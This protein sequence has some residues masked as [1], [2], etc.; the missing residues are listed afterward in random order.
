MWNNFEQ[1]P[2]EDE[3]IS[4][5][6][7]SRGIFRITSEDEILH[8][9]H[10]QASV[11]NKRMVVAVDKSI[12]LLEDEL[13]AK[14]F[15]LSFNA[16]ID[17][18]AISH[19]GNL[20]VCGLSDGEI[21]GIYIKGLP[22]F[23][24]S[25][26]VE[27]VHVVGGK[28][29]AGIQQVGNTFCVTCTNGSVYSLTE[30]DE[31]PL[32]DKLNASLV[33]NDITDLEKH[34][35]IVCLKRLFTIRGLNEI[36]AALLITQNMDYV[37]SKQ[38]EPLVIA[39]T[40]NAV[41]LRSS[42]DDIVRLNIPEMY[43]GVKEIYNLENF[44]VILTNS[45]H[46]LELCP[47]TKLLLDTSEITD[48][49]LLIDNLIVMDC[50]DEHIEFLI[51]TKHTKQE[52]RCIKIVDYP[53]LKCHNE[54]DVSEHSWLV[55]QP[56]CS[57]NLYYLSGGECNSN[58]LPTILEMILVSET[59]PSERFKK[60]IAK[61][62]LEEAEDFGRQFEL[63]LQP[64]YEAKAKK[65]LVEMNSLG[66]NNP[67]LLNDLFANLMELLHK[68]ENKEFFRQNRMFNIPSRKILEKYLKEVLN[69]LD[70]E[71]DEQHI[72]EIVEQLDRLKTL[73]ILDPYEVNMEW[74][75][76]VYHPNLI[77]YIN[78]LFKTDMSMASLIWKRHS[79][80]I[81]PQLN[82]NELRKLLSLIPSDTKPFNILQWLRQFV[83]VVSNTH[84]NIMPFITDWSIEK[85]R[86]LQYAEHWPEIGL[87]FSTKV[88]E[89]FED[90]QFMHS[91]VRRQH[92]RNIS[93][94]RDLVNALQDLFVLKKSYNL[95]FTLDN[96]LQD[97]IDETA[98]CILLRVHLDNL[99]SLVNDFLYPIYQEKG[100]SP[101]AAIRRYICQL[102]ASR[103]SF[104]TWLERSVACI[105]LLH[106]EDDR[107]ES[108]L[109]VLQNSP[110]PWPDTVDPLI[111]LRYSTHPLALKINTEY[112]IQVIKIMKAKY[113]WPT[114]C[115]SDMNLNLFMFRIIKMD[116]PDMLDDIRILTKAA[117]EIA[118]AAN[119]N[120]CYQMVRKGKPDVACDFFKSLKADI[121]PKHATEVAELFAE[122]L[123]QSPTPLTDEG[124]VEQKNLIEFFKFIT[125]KTCPTAQKRLKAIQNRFILRHKYDLQINDVIDLAPYQNRLHLLSM[126]L[127]NVIKRSQETDN[128]CN[129]FVGEI[130][131]L[132]SALD[133]SKMFVVKRLCQRTK[134]LIITCA[135]TY[136]MLDIV[137]CNKEN[138][139]DFVELALELL[140]Q[141]IQLTKSSQNSST[142]AALLNDNDPLAFPLAYELLVRAS[143]VETGQISELAELINYVRI[144]TTGYS[145]GAISQF[146]ENR[147]K[148][149]SQ[150]ICEA[151]DA[152]EITVGEITL[153]FSTNLNNSFDIKQEIKPKKRYS[154]SVF[155]DV[156]PLPTQASQTKVNHSEH[157]HI[158]KFVSRTLL[159]LI[160]QAP[161]TNHLLIKLKEF[162]FGSNLDIK[163]DVDSAKD[164]FF[165]SLEHLIK[166]K[167]HT[168]WYTMAQYV[169]DYQRRHNCKLINCDFVSLQMG[170]VF[171]H[172]L[173]QKDV[174]FLDLFIMLISD[175]HATMLL[176]KLEHDLKTD[177]QKVNFLILSEMY[178]VHS[179]DTINV[180]NIR[181]KRIKHFYYMEFCK[182]DPSIKGKFN[183]DIDSIEQLLKEFHNKQLDVSLLERMSADFNLD[184]QKMLI[185]QVISILQAQEMQF[186]IKIDSFGDEELVMVT[187]VDSIRNL[188]QPYINEIKNTELLTSKLK[189][190]IDEINLYFYELYLCVIEILLYF[191][192]VP[193]EMQVWTSILHFL[194][195]KMVVRRRN[196]PGQLENDMW[197]ESQKEIGV[198]PKIARYRLPFKP[199]VEQPLKDILDS[200]LNVDN[201]ESWFPLIQMHTVLKG[202]TDIAHNCD[203]FCMSA[204][205]NS[206]TEYKS[207]DDGETW[208]LQPTNN[209]FL[210]SILR[211]VK[212]V[213]NPS[214]AFLILYFVSNYAP[215]GADQVEASYECYKYCIE[216]EKEITDSK[217]QEQIIKIKRNFPILKTQHLLY[218]YG[219]TD[220]KTMRLIENPTELIYHLYHHDILLKGGKLDINTVV[221]EI[222]ELHNLNL[223]T[224]QFKLLQKW[225]SFTVETPDGTVLDETL[226]EDQNLAEN[227]N[228]DSGTSA[229]NV[230]RANYV[231]N[232]WPKEVAVQFL[233]AHIFPADGTVNTSKQLQMYE[234][235]FK[236]YDGSKSFDNTLSQK[237]YITIKCVHELKKLGYNS[238]LDKFANSNKIDI[239]KTIWQRNTHNANTLQILA[240]ICL[241][242]DIYLSKVW[243]GILKRMV[244]IGMVKELNALVDLLS[245][246]PQLLHTEGLILAWDFV[247]MH[248]FKNAN[249]TKSVEQE[250][251]LH[252]TLFRL[253]SCPVVHSLNLLKFAENCERLNRPHMAAILLAFCRN[254]EQRNQIKSLISTRNSK[255][256]QDILDLEDAGI[257]PFI[258]NFALKEL[259]L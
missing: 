45:G 82:E 146:Y 104:S 226:F 216:H 221:K 20:I 34:F 73:A 13:V 194:K 80:A 68:I 130:S 121:N 139:N 205:K 189:Q 98:K 50:N 164:D 23:S 209:A 55:Q 166:N 75:K 154:V 72:L 190:F 69:H 170:R 81:L 246:K 176:E 11:Q 27:D 217:C 244:M 193:K 71:M 172:L 15:V 236:L 65:I 58:D 29:F 131:D 255:M 144:A 106:N 173:S 36:T 108:A 123:E 10:V 155:D 52:E 17:V 41:Y 210:K 191:E 222:A 30:I 179:E 196:R 28:T 165:V 162:I 89:I 192:A 49:P 186:E 201:C 105:D 213:H 6:F 148:E 183:A 66:D 97:S 93:K 169:L 91:D 211:L 202:S 159:F 46:L 107:L 188:C 182:Q 54:L 142:L 18:L 74:Q 129:Y 8:H 33:E 64:I 242:F 118:T 4:N 40:Y 103:N 163:I 114:D 241:G 251:I 203:Y 200:E 177:Q 1:S 136:N 78:S 138:K 57:V 180:E 143:V 61:G 90:I 86:S 113:N 39:G 12:F 168:V 227:A 239:L 141:Q 112:E 16:N 48:P 35:A 231:I 83:P 258:L 7:S 22:L 230:I 249:Q 56:K 207:R 178:N 24:Q 250:E 161:P 19:T 254:E 160:V 197:F 184:Y 247:L 125:P 51:L 195:H 109:L 26:K 100:K 117:P 96:Y 115:A 256:R 235:Y 248:P 94:L 92:E 152:S 47:Y 134:C 233:V 232:S 21:H 88:T 212:H 140:A 44:I 63:C 79:C 99:K 25:I 208:H 150:L 149:I 76:F 204:V 110:V 174:N 220:E 219:L 38:M 60:L 70:E 229:E 243:N 53:G 84:P 228:E 171:R 253:Q 85:T 127:E 95:I 234:C 218:I 87:E 185:A 43:Q 238:S 137:D 14:C 240:N 156:A 9:P 237:Q 102:V 151:I 147:E 124:I 245:C 37:D 225:L 215:D 111:K 206:I 153:N 135:I 116:L 223:E 59:H 32:E 42:P 128:V 67:E 214:K 126:A 252:K 77:K 145:S 3:T 187:T 132:A 257:L 224:I 158:V 101:V 175:P 181:T 133:L 5:A 31:S 120:C 199:I 157:I 167:M 2:L 198:L 259:K 122:V 119:F 62:H